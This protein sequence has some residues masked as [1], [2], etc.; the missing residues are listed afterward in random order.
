MTK[1][2]D[3]PLT[4]YRRENGRVGIRNHVLIISVD[5][6][7]NAAVTGV[8]RL[9]RGTFALPHPYGRLQ[10][11]DDLDLTFNTLIGYGKNPNV[12]AAIVI[13]IEPNWSNYIADQ[14][15]E[16]GKPVTA[17]SIE[18]T[19]DLQTIADAS[20]KAKEYVHYATELPRVPIEW[21]EILVSTKCGESDTTSGLA[22]NPTVGRVFDRLEKLGNTMIF[23]ETTEVTGAEDKVM[24]RCVNPEVEAGFK[25]AF[26]DYQ[27]LV[28]SQGVNLM[29]SQPTEGNIRGG[30]TTIEEKALGNVEKM[31]NCKVVGYLDQ[32]EAPNGPPGLY[33]MDSSSAAA[34]QVTLCCAGG[35]TLHLFTTGQGNIVGNPVLPTIKMSANPL[36]CETMSEHIDVDLSGLL[37]F[38]YNLDGAADRTMEMMARTINGRL[39]SAETLRHDDFVITKLYRSA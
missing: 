37:R 2:T 30:L 4:G 32:A 16:T 9:I 7:S 11:G 31:G 23:G 35:A 36:T 33:F 8:E 27:D 5:D 26:D 20:R 1:Y 25:K 6:I 18:R 34:E 28:K 12:A 10:F 21:N 38:E 15:A 17:F 24:E 29:G 14:I 39:T 19:G 13:G 3:I 22:S